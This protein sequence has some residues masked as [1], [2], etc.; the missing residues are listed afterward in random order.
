MNNCNKI[1]VISPNGETK[2]CPVIPL[3]ALQVFASLKA[4]NFDVRFIDLCFVS[5]KINYLKQIIY[6]IKPKIIIFSIRNIDNETML[7]PKWYLHEVFSMINICRSDFSKI[8]IGG[9][10][11]SIMP[12]EI[13]N[14]L[15]PDFGI[16]GSDSNSLIALVKY[17]FSDNISTF[18]LRTIPSLVFSS[19]EKIYSNKPR[20]YNNQFA[21]YGYSDF[22]EVIDERYVSFN[23]RQCSPPCFG[24]Q[25]SIGCNFNCIHC[26]IPKIEGKYQ[27][28]SLDKVIEHLKSLS[29]KDNNHRVFFVDNILNQNY[30][31]SFSLCEEIIRNKINIRWTCFLHPKIIDE[32]LIQIMKRSGCESVS[33]GIDTASESLLGLWQKGF[34]TSDIVNVAK[35]CNKYGIR[36]LFSLIFGSIGET[37]KTLR[38]SLTFITRINPSLVWG[39]WGVRVYPNTLLYKHLKKMNILDCSDNFLSPK[40]F[41]SPEIVNNGKQILLEFSSQHS[42]FKVNF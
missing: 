24:I 42:Y 3:G 19:C 6:Q 14:Y 11:F 12:F 7:S 30:N 41:I 31:D 37:P 13:F 39:A 22:E 29:Q 40:Y 38:E 10:G 34:S 9:I 25:T 33:I 18:K 35:Y 2:P 23:Q 32:Q 15:R 27:K 21:N 20:K 8:I 26:L 1:L 4:N 5:D 16:L 17:I 36:T 28:I